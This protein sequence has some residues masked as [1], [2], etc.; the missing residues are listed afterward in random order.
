MQDF[1]APDLDLTVN[2]R[3]NLIVRDRFVAED[4]FHAE[5]LARRFINNLGQLVR[6]QDSLS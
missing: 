1:P 2:E 4:A 5:V 3:G 6:D